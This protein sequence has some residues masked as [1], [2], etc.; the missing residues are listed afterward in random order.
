[1]TTVSDDD[2]TSEAG[3]EDGGSEN[4]LDDNLEDNYSGSDY[5][6]FVSMGMVWRGAGAENMDR[7][8]ELV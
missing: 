2:V 4:D 3:V 1:M 8:M 7:A 5:Q 6:G